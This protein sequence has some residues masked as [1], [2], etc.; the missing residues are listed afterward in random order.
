MASRADRFVAKLKKF[1]GTLPAPPSDAFTL[2]VWEILS[3]HSSDKKRSAAMAALK[4]HGAL[5]VDGM[6]NCPPRKIE[7]S[8]ALAGPYVAQRVQALKKGVEAFRR[9]PELSSDIRRPHREAMRALKGIPLMGGEG[10]GYRMLL[11]PGGQAV[12]PMDARFARVATRL[13]YGQRD[14]VNFA[15]TAKSVRLAIA[16][17]TRDSVGAY[18]ELYIHFEH[19]GGAICTESDPKCDE[20]PL[21]KDCPFAQSQHL[22]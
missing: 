14:D 10:S 18:R 13:G 9:N 2:F 17:E 6:W 11:F 12:L 22:R 8:V 20:C 3:N 21:V 4:K 19:H 16:R 5:T 1:Y 15:K 7:E